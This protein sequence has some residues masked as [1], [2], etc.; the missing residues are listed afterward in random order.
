M[1]FVFTANLKHRKTKFTALILRKHCRLQKKRR[2]FLQGPP[3]CMLRLPAKEQF[4]MHIKV[5]LFLSADFEQQ[6]FV[7]REWF[8][9]FAEQGF[10]L[11][12]Y[13]AGFCHGGNHAVSVGAGNGHHV[14]G[15][16]CSDVLF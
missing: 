7:A 8:V 2:S 11:V 3:L 12:G 15:G 9:F 5:L 16:F 6:V 1:R 4:N 10:D 14:A 13:G